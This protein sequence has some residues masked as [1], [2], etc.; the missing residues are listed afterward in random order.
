MKALLIA[1]LLALPLAASAADQNV[2]TWVP[3]TGGGPVANYNVERTTAANVPACGTATGFAAITSV[4][5]PTTTFTDTG[6]TENVT[7]CYRINAQNSAGISPYSN[8]SGR[9]VPITA[10]ATPSL[11]VN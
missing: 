2:L 1:L 9:T 5:A 6:L 8:I 7:Y 11:S 10:P 4:V 3:G